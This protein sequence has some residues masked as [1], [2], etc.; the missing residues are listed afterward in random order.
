MSGNDLSAHIAR[1][2][3]RSELVAM[4]EEFEHFA[5]DGAPLSTA[6]EKVREI[7]AKTEP[8][9]LTTVEELD[10]EEASNALCLVTED[11]SA[12]YGFYSRRDGQ[13]EWTAMGTDEFFTSSELLADFAN[14]G[15]EARF[16]LVTREP[17]NL[18]PV[19]PRVLRTEDDLN[20]EEAF[21]ALCIM[22]YG[23]PLRTA[24]S[25]TDG[26]NYWQEPGYEGEY[27]SAELLAHF[28]KIGAEPA[29]TLIR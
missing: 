16:M 17:E 9:I 2:N 10:S 20:S 14:L 26:V 25:R 29:F 18:L 13:N 11:G 12:A 8:K 19:G 28:A 27:S 23:G 22:P 24:S 3:L 5:Y 7:L 6:T 15:D 4:L 1:M 21:T